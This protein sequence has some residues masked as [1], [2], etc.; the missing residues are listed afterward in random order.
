MHITPT[1]RFTVISFVAVLTSVGTAC[2]ARAVPLPLG[3]ALSPVRDE[4]SPFTGP[5]STRTTLVSTLV[6]DTFNGTVTTVVIP[7]DPGNALGGLTF[8]YKVANLDTDADPARVT[9]LGLLGSGLGRMDVSVLSR[10]D[11]MPSEVDRN[12][13]GHVGFSFFMPAIGRNDS[14]SWL[15]LQ[16]DAPAFRTGV[17]SLFSDDT[18]LGRVTTLVTVPEPAMAA[19]AVVAPLLLRRARTSRSLR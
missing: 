18:L 14:S 10:D 13:E 15:I 1:M 9:R 8:V 19:T 3:R 4:G 2:V 7:D 17:A 6:T 5:T 12:T 16:T 11:V